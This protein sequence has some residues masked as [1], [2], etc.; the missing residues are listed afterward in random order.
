M[1]STVLA[2]V[3][4]LGNASAFTP[5]LHGGRATTSLK[6]GLEYQVPDATAEGQAPYYAQPEADVPPPGPEGSPLPPAVHHHGVAH[7]AWPHDPYASAT[8]EEFEWVNNQERNY[9]KMTPNI[10]RPYEKELDMSC[11][12]KQGW[13]HGPHSHVIHH[14]HEWESNQERNYS[15]QKPSIYRPYPP[16]AEINL[17]GGMPRKGGH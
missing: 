4:L 8:V 9:G 15:Q 11:G 3:A 6:S 2:L 13:P 1:T 7:G 5:S 14:E 17:S 16:E 10:Y 12:I